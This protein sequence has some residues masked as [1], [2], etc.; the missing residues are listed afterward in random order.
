MI[1]LQLLMFLL[2]QKPLLFAQLDLNT[3]ELFDIFKVPSESKIIKYFENEEK[4]I[5]NVYYDLKIVLERT[6]IKWTSTGFEPY[7]SNFEL[8]QT[9]VRL[10]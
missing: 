10:P 3:S 4:I 7:M 1:F 9:Q 8:F 6:Q 2:L 5:T